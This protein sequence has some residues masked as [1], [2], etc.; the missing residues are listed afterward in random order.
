MFPSTFSATQ[1]K[2]N[3]MD[4]GNMMKMGGHTA[5]YIIIEEQRTL[6]CMVIDRCNG[7]LG[8]FLPFK[9]AGTGNNSKDIAISGE[10]KFRLKVDITK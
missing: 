4:V 9:T 8:N 1:N 5:V 6:L 3:I 10:S 7:Y 2:K